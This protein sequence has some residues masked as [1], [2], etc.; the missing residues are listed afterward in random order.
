M[1]CCDSDVGLRLMQ[2]VAIQYL[3]GGVWV[4]LPRHVRLP[5]WSLLP[6]TARRAYIYEPLPLRN[7]IH[8]HCSITV[9]LSALIHL[10]SDFPLLLLCAILKQFL[11]DPI[12]FLFLTILAQLQVSVK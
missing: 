3:W 5:L 11:L 4:L 12:A 9:L 8:H 2:R 10:S 6:D 1:R 7:A